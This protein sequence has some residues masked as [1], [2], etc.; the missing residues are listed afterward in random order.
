MKRVLADGVYYYDDKGGLRRETWS[1]TNA[2]ERIDNLF[3]YIDSSREETRDL[4]KRVGELE[5]LHYKD[6]PYPEDHN[7]PE[8]THSKSKFHTCGECVNPFWRGDYGLCRS[9]PVVRKG[10]HPIAIWR[11]HE[12][13][14]NFKGE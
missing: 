11:E 12:A 14:E 5:T 13:C 2:H 3:K 10:C 8:P 1:E 6:Q 4:A 9:H 7:Y